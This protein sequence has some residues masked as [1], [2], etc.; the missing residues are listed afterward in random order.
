[1][2]SEY[3]VNYFVLILSFSWCAVKGCRWYAHHEDQKMVSGERKDRTVTRSIHL[4]LSQ[5]GA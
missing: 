1:M 5:T 2:F 3:V 4:T